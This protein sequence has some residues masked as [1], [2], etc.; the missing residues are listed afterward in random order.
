M[1][2]IQLFKTLTIVIILLCCVP[3]LLLLWY[4]R[5]DLLSSFRNLLTRPFNAKPFNEQLKVL[6]VKNFKDLFLIA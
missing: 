1:D 6:P 2:N 5:E 4:Y 3:L